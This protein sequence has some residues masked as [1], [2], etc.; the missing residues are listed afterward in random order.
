ME[1]VVNEH[2][3]YSINPQKYLKV[4]PQY[5]EE[6]FKFLHKICPDNKLVWDCA[7]GNGQ[8]AHLLSDYFTTVHA[9]DI[10]PSQLDYAI[11]KENINYYVADECNAVLND[12]SVDLITVATA[13]HW[14]DRKKFYKEVE[15]VLKP[16]G[17]LAIWGYTGK[18]VNPELDD[19]LHLIIKKHLM[20]YYSER[21]QLAFD[22]YD[23]IDFP[24]E[25]IHTPSF[26]TQVDYTFHDLLDYI[27]S[28][29]S[30]QRYI[31]K[32]KVSPI[33]LFENLLKEAWGD[34]NKHKTMTWDFITH[35]G[36]KQ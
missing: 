29:S 17:I 23:A 11:Q 30:S 6:M 36:K 3:E 19:V 31:Q 9:T 27:L 2:N 1:N 4:R 13:I 18:N 16:D 24:Y 7:T 26:K 12:R 10:N 20:P 15:R 33:P 21:I 34:I 8:A 22:G 32:N 28:W 5:G 35:I 14:F 25:R